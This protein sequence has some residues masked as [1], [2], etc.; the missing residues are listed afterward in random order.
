MFDPRA[1]WFWIFIRKPS[2]KYRVGKCRQVME[3]QISFL[4]P[5]FAS[6]DHDKSGSPGRPRP[7]P[8]PARGRRATSKQ[9]PYRPPAVTGGVPC[10]CTNSCGQTVRAKPQ[11]DAQAPERWEM[12]Q[13][14]PRTSPGRTRGPAREGVAPQ[15]TESV[16]H[17]TL[18]QIF[19]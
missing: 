11:T 18:P 19:V 3:L 10:G 16:P 1:V 8:E 13:Q 17:G 2:F 5:A 9:L 6:W 7:P 14:R 4:Y 12:A 15:G